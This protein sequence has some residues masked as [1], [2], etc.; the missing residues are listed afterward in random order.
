MK[1][2]GTSAATEA[3]ATG[4]LWSYINADL[5]STDTSTYPVQAPVSGTAY[6]YENWL[7]LECTAAP[8]NQCN[9]F[10]FWGANTQPDDPTNLLTIKD[11]T[12]GTGATPT[13]N[14][15]TA[16]TTTQHTTHTGS[17]SGLAIGVVP[18]DSIINAIAEQTNYLVLQMHLA[19]GAASGNGTAQ[20]YHWGYDES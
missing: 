1:C 12:T 11:G 17:G 13:N 10:K 5:N 18:G 2:T 15:S 19:V 4:G 6:S 14:V 20:V 3:E 7:R 16:A 8:D 9:N